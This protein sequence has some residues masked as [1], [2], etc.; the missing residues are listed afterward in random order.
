MGRMAEK[1]VVKIL[2]KIM[3]DLWYGIVIKIA[4]GFVVRFMVKNFKKT[5]CNRR[6]CRMTLTIRE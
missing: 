1:Y 3:G 5:A 2:V 4:G 6:V